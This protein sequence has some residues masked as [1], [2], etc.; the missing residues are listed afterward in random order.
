MQKPTY[1]ILVCGRGRC[2]DRQ[3]S[4]KVEAKLQ[5]L[6]KTHNLDDLTHPQS[7]T[8]RLVNCLAVCEAGV[9]LMVHPEAILYHQI[10]E[11]SA[12]Q[13]FYEHI[14]NNQPVNRLQRKR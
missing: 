8:C 9:V 1:R 12:E 13:I 7:A 6:I 10:D 5:H 14:L 3:L 4:L 11:D 2:V